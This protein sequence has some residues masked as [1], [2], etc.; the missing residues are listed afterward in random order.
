M[1]KT[2]APGFYRMMLGGFEVTAL[3]DGVVSM[4]IVF[5][6]ITKEEITTRLAD[7]YLTEP[8]PMSFNAFLINTGNKLV[9]IDVGTGDLGEILEWSGVG[10]VVDNLRAAGYRPEQ[11]DEIYITHAHIDHVGG[12]L[13]GKRRAF[14]NATVRAATSESS[15]YLD[16]ER[17]ATVFA[18]ASGKAKAVAKIIGTLFKSYV[19][20]G[21]FRT[22][23][24]D[25][26]LVPG[27]SAL[28]TPGHT[29]GHTT[30][31][32]KSQGQTLIVLGDLVHHAA[33]QFPNPWAP[34][35]SDFDAKAAT[36]QRIRM[37]QLAATQGYWVAAAHISF[38]G[39][40]HIRTDRGSY[41]WIPAAYDIAK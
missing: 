9:L 5:P 36:S 10:H 37:F 15:I 12:L 38:P 21:K 39:I 18:N 13:Q 17:A 30:Y 40:G 14:P 25:I 35:A 4:P 33:V 29:P 24:G 16:P 34:A 22:F 1:V 27:I 11:V 8:V 26:E 28:G 2:Q 6:G 19:D 23:D 41:V 7:M 32:V 20:A 31:L 3:S